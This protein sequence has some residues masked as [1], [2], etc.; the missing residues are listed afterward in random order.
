MAWIDNNPGHIMG[1]LEKGN[2][3]TKIRIITRPNK[4]LVWLF[5]FAAALLC[6]EII[7]PES[8]VPVAKN[9]KIAFL[10]GVNSILILLIV[11]FRNGVKKRFEELMQL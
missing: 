8:L 1:I 3:G 10:V 9:L 11:L 4:F 6:L 7:Q 5:Y 2:E